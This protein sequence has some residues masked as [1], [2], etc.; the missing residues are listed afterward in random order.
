MNSDL[1]LRLYY[2]RCK[3]SLIAHQIDSFNDYI[4]HFIPLLMAQYN[5]IVVYHDY[6]EKINK[7][8]TEIRI[9][10]HFNKIDKPIL[11]EIN[12]SVTNLYPHDARL[13]SLTYDST[14]Y[15]DMF[16]EVFLYE[17]D[18]N[19]IVKH[20]EKHLKKINFGKIP[21]MLHSK[22]CLLSETINKTP[23]EMGECGADLGGYFIINGSEKVIITH[24]RQAENKVY[25]FKS[26]KSTKYSHIVE[27]KSMGL[28]RLLPSKT[29]NV[30]INAKE[31]SIWGKT[32][33]VSCSQFNQD[34]PLF[35]MFRALGIESDHGIIERIVYDCEDPQTDILI[36]LLRPSLEEACDIMTQFQAFEYLSRHVNILGHPKESKLDNDKRIS[37]VKDAL[38]NDI[39]PH[40]GQSLIMKGI[41]LGYMTRKILLYYLDYIQEDDRDSYSKKRLD[42]PGLLL[43]NLTRQ[44][45][46]KIIKDMRNALMKEMNNGN[47]KYSKDINDLINQTNIYKIIKP[48]TLG[49]MKYS[50]ATGTW[51]M[52]GTI[53]KVGVCQ[54]LNRLSSNSS[55]S[56]LRRVNTPIDK[57]SKLVQPRKLHGTSWGYICPA[58]TPEGSP[59]G[60][61]K[62]LA[63]GCEISNFIDS[64]TVDPYLPIVGMIPLTE[65]TPAKIFATHF[66]IF[67]NG[68]LKGYTADPISVRQRLCEL[69]QQGIIHPHI[70]ITL[71]I[72]QR[73]L[74]I[75]TEAG[76]VIRPIFI[77]N[78]H[79]QQLLLTPL[80]RQLLQERKLTWTNLITGFEYNHTYYPAIIQY[81]DAQE[82]EHSLIAM[83]YVDLQTS[84]QN[85][86]RYTH[87]EIEPSLMLGFLASLIPFSDH[88]QSPRNTYQ[89]AM[90][91][92]AMGIY[93]LNFADRMDTLGNILSYPTRPIVNTKISKYLKQ[94][95]PSG[96]NV[97]VAIMC[98]SGFNQEDSI[99]I[100]QSAVERGLFHS[101]FYRTYKDEEKKNQASGVE[102]K[103]TRPNQTLTRG[104]KPGSYDHLDE[105]GFPKLNS[106]LNGGDVIIGKV[107]PIK[108]NEENDIHTAKPFRDQSTTIRYNE[109]GIVDKVFISRNGDGYRTAKVRVRC[110][111][112]PQIG[113]KF[114][115]RHGQKGTVGIIYRQQDMPFTKEGLIPDIII[116]PHAI[117][118]RMTI[119]QLIEC[120]VGK[121]CCMLGIPEAD[122][123]PF[124]QLNVYNV[125]NILQTQCHM[126]RHGYEILYNGMIGKQLECDVFI[127]PTFYQ[128][129]RHMV[130]DKIHAR[131]EGPRVALTHQPA[132]GR[133]RD[134]GLRFGEMERDCVIA[135]GVAAFSKERMLEMSDNYR[136]FISNRTGLISAVNYEKN[137]FRPFVTSNSIH[138]DIINSYTEIRIPYSLKLLF[139]EL[140]TMAIAPRFIVKNQTEFDTTMQDT[141]KNT[142]LAKA[143]NQTSTTQLSTTQTQSGL[144]TK[145]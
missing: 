113:D 79:T 126:Q 15:V 23:N 34:I 55:F 36:H 130:A 78:S 80:H 87:C 43:A 73:E 97:I 138:P 131:S 116:N 75:Q 2:E 84:K 142:N 46:T 107:I 145:F 100:N 50:L 125:G 28:N 35:I 92:Q 60:V 86:C 13:R 67:L 101:T 96:I 137:I 8:R 58:E 69:R 94:E 45:L 136:V 65:N 98:Y 133:S 139:Q 37:Y 104:L 140:Q 18:N 141:R 61:V 115:S 121:S 44:Y 70:S 39:L 21:I 17:G 9:R 20:Q 53:N 48:T 108:T 128:R 68:C 120:I 99:I 38:N 103:F 111:R 89:S 7:F 33:C 102:E 82:S 57:S 134:G 118:S 30:K 122:G 71:M 41:F 110:R 26:A 91:K 143:Q 90:G 32:L 74:Q 10:L 129:L 64:T 25:C 31:N 66:L 4:D 6:D 63:M 24:E 124:N 52:K 127:G 12:G 132:E 62:N 3:Y 114:S 77:V 76:R 117:P 81:I 49:G 135:H 88:N 47:W 123:T 5:P 109:N 59:I 56:H 106:V 93:C 83:N 119:A 112:I 11:H 144:L 22:L 29:L 105:K 51:G 42:T 85:L 72:S 14:L 40:M 27:I 95:A 19:E 54:V 16:V 1:F